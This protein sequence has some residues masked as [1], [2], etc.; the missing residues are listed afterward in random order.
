MPKKS[1]SQAREE[2]LNPNV[3]FRVY[4]RGV[5]TNNDAWVWN[6]D[7]GAQTVQTKAQIVAYNAALDACW[8]SHWMLPP[9]AYISHPARNFADWLIVEIVGGYD[10]TRDAVEVRFAADG[11]HWT[12]TST[13]WC[14]FEDLVPMK[15]VLNALD[16]TAAGVLRQDPLL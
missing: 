13:G 14:R 3:I 11:R 1:L 2:A 12:N 8:G 16:Q 5:C 4:S 7:L 6:Y 10:R 9:N 15:A